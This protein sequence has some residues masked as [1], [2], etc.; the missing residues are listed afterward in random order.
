V[1]GE[2][3]SDGERTKKRGAEQHTCKGELIVLVRSPTFRSIY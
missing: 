3:E 1:M 2:R